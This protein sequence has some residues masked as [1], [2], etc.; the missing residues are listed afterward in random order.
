VYDLKPGR[1][2]TLHG[3]SDPSDYKTYTFSYTSNSTLI[4]EIQASTAMSTK[5]E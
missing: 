2:I 5:G 3:R 1:P 4:P